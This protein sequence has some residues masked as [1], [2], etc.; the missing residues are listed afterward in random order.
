MKFAKLDRLGSG[1]PDRKSRRQLTRKACFESLET[2]W[3]RAALPFGAEP[4][5]T[6]EFMLGR[7]AVTPILLESNGQLNTST[8]NWNQAHIDESLSKLSEGL[9]WWKEL[10]GKT[11]TVHSLDFVIDRT[12]A[13]R[14][15]PTA[16]EPIERVSN[17]YALWTQEFLMRVGYAQSSSLEENMR[18]FNIA[19][20]QKANADWS[21]TVFIVNSEAE[22]DGTFAQG[23]SFSR[24]FAFAG[25]LFFVVP[26]TRPASTFA[27]ET[28]HMFW[29]RDEY[30]GSSSYYL[31]RGYY[32]TQNSNSVDNNPTPNF[33]QAPSIM[34]SGASLQTAY[35][36]VESP[37]STLAMIGWQDSDSDGIFDVLDVPLKLDGVGRVDF[38]SGTYRF[39]GLAQAQTLPN[40]NSSGLGNDIT[41]NK[42]SRIEV[43]F[44][45]GPWQTV[46]QPDAAVA[47]LD[48]T[49]PL[50]GRQSGSVQ[51]RAVDAVTGITSKIFEGAISTMPDATTLVGINGF[52]WNDANGNG[53]FDAA[54]SGLGAQQV[55]LVDDSGKVLNLR[56]AV[57][58]DEKLPGLI[59][60]SAYPGLAI[61]ST[62][63]DTNGNVGVFN[64]TAAS[65]GARV[66]RPYSIGQ[67]GYA[68]NWTDRRQLRLDF[69]TPTSLVSID[70]IGSG[71][72]SYGRLELYNSNGELL[73]RVT[74]AALTAGQVQAVEIGRPTPDIAYALVRGHMGTGVKLDNLHFGPRTQLSTDTAGRYAFTNLPVAS[75]HVQ[76]VLPTGT[77]TVTSAAGSNQLI[78]LQ[79]N[80]TVQHV[81]FG[82]NFQNSAWHNVSTAQDV[83]NDGHITAIDVLIVIN[84]LNQTNGN[85]TLFGSSIPNRPYVDVSNDGF[86][87]ALDALLVINAINGANGAGEQETTAGSGS[88]AAGIASSGG[89]TPVGEGQAA[90][91]GSG[92][93]ARIVAPVFNRYSQPI[94]PVPASQFAGTAA[95]GSEGESVASLSPATLTS[96]FSTL[97]SPSSPSTPS[98]CIV[99]SL[100]GAHLQRA[101]EELRGK[102]STFDA[103]A[104]EN[105]LI[106]ET[107]SIPIHAPL[108][109]RATELD[110]E[111]FN[112]DL[113]AR[114][115]ANPWTLPLPCTCAACM[116][117][118]Q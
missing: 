39:A 11:S 116:A 62:G 106:Q 14:P 35:D 34:S 108:A 71:S 42:V 115:Q 56:K 23:G 61:S 77:S 58:P 36:N 13:D 96:A 112:A 81:D 50:G 100:L 107:P 98:P 66:F 21:F 18:A 64:D 31:Q 3:V 118:S 32:S 99:D 117:V 73:D 28:G 82:L 24:A 19:Q 17:D 15:V 29:A 94:G 86:V 6:G 54:E 113:I 76:V 9:D 104:I 59:Q 20:R 101:E 57:E 4:A 10:L 111:L 74:T 67:G 45:D 103:S 87:T 69:A 97:A 8:E 52:V 26:S 85:G 40:R 114:L 78:A 44:A 91:G 95:P 53:L 1:S 93:D 2:R 49:I 63:S 75:Y 46:T 55:R 80:P 12:Y 41:L 90:G 72:K 89:N 38:N 92:E 105:A 60:S 88:G 83:N 109:A 110:S 25:G 33:Q 27:H 65:T 84:L 7:I 79:S 102:S 68:D 16:Y 37:P 30:S 5:D 22:R 51:L 70:V 43:R 47:T 48:L